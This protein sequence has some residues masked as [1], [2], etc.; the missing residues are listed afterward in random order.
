MVGTGAAKMA[1]TGPPGVFGQLGWPGGAGGAKTGCFGAVAACC[2][3]VQATG[4][5]AGGRLCAKV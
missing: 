4:G 2:A 3:V 5:M 1:D